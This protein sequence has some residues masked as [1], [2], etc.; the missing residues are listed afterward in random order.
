MLLGSRPSQALDGRVF[1]IGKG[2]LPPLHINCRST[3][4]AKLDSRFDFLDEGATRATRDGSVSAK[5]T[6]YDWL[7]TQPL[8]VQQNVLGKTRA[9]IFNDKS[10]TPEKF[11]KLNMG[12]N[13][14]PITL[15]E[16]RKKAPDAYNRVLTS[17]ELTK[18]A[19]KAKITPSQQQKAMED[20]LGE[21]RYRRLAGSNE[22]KEI[23]DKM[24]ELGLTQ[25]EG[26]AI[27]AYTGSYHR[28]Y[29]DFLWKKSDQDLSSQVDVLR[30]AM[31]KLPDYKGVSYRRTTLPADI[32]DQHKIGSVVEYKAFTSSSHTKEVFDGEHR[33]IITGKTGKKVGWISEFGEYEREVLFNSP[34]KFYVENRYI[35]DDGIL[36]IK[37][38]EI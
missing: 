28:D 31:D 17:K 35:S 7:K 36:T 32:L 37:L 6:Y 19:Q 33:L 25:A 5:M 15:S 10:M 14:K 24:A 38:I 23:K 18:Q 11:A 26:A 8:E 4:L 3:F 13:H 16:W 27:R 20:W 30:S 22:K 2:P 34:K 12:R 1:D 21:K 29:N 9:G